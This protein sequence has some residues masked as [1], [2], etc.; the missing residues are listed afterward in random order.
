[1]QTDDS[2]L[3][4][5]IYYELYLFMFKGKFR[6][7]RATETLTQPAKSLHLTSSIYLHKWT[8]CT[9]FN[10]WFVI[11][12]AISCAKCEQNH[13]W[14]FC[15]SKAIYSL[16]PHQVQEDQE[17]HDLP[18]TTQIDSIVTKITHA[19]IKCLDLAQHALRHST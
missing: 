6:D 17:D 9:E 15:L 8:S 3:I 12:N 5:D 10:I 7:N 4:H 2:V 16:S 14:S 13:I 18:K 1:M 19:T 11:H